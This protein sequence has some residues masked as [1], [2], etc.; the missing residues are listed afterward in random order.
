MQIYGFGMHGEALANGPGP[1]VFD[2]CTD[3]VNA[4]PFVK[5]GTI[6]G[7]TAPTTLM[8]P[9]FVRRK[10]VN[11]GSPTIGSSHETVN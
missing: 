7:E 3:T 6:T 8:N 11:G 5:P 4:T 9:G 1:T 2:A 10:K